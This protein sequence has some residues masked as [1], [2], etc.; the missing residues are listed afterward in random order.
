MGKFVLCVETRIHQFEQNQIS[1]LDNLM[2]TNKN[3]TLLKIEH[4]QVIFEIY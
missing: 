1:G 4:G 3:C 2:M